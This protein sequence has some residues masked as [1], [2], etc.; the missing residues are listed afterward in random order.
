MMELTR[1][2]EY[3]IRGMLYLARLQDRQSAMIDEVARAMLVPRSFLAKIFQELSVK[4]LIKSYKGQGGGVALARPCESIT[5]GEIVEAIEGPIMPNTCLMGDEACGFKPTC[6]VHP[7][8][9][10]LQAV[11]KGI[12]AEVS[13]KSLSQ[14]T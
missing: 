7:V 4:G 3:A 9:R 6:P 1:K 13:L 14:G 11:T 10:R 5:L 8:W 12:L 2:A